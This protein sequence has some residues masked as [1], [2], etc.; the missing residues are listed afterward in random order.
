MD[1]FYETIAETPCI[2]NF[3]NKHATVISK[4]EAKKQV[5]FEYKID[6]RALLQ[7]TF[8]LRLKSMRK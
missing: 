3:F 2:V 7:L 8:I 5:D 6:D 4:Q 1:F